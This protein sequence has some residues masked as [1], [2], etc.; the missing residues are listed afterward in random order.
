MPLPDRSS[1]TGSRAEGRTPERVLKPCLKC[2]KLIPMTN[3]ALRYCARCRNNLFR[4]RG[5][6]ERYRNETVE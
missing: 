4:D 1:E 5:Y 6:E 3:P 2:Q